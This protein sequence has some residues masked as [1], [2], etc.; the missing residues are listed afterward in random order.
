MTESCT[1]VRFTQFQSK[2]FLRTN[3]SQGSVATHTRSDGI[4]HY[5]F[6]IDS[7][8]SRSVNEFSKSIIIRQMYGQ[9]YSDTFF[10]DMVN[11]SIF[12]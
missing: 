8:L 9:K 6:S 7:L 3:I 4:V 11:Q 2:A 1:T 10:P 12:V 5:Q